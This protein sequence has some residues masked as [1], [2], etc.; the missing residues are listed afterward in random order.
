MGNQNVV[1]FADARLRGGGD[2]TSRI[3]AI[4]VRPARVDQKGLPR[5]RDEQGRLS[6]LN[7]HKVD[8]QV[9]V[10][11]ERAPPRMRLRG[12]D[13]ESRGMQPAAGKASV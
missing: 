3:A 1:N 13:T 11:V 12:Q 2:N 6:A 7:I 9:F 10:F 4:I 5:G 8:V